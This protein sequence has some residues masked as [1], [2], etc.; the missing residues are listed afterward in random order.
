M[1]PYMASVPTDVGS[2]KPINFNGEKT[3]IHIT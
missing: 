3:E 2:R 1:L